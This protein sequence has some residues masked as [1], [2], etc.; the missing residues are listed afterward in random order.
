MKALVAVVTL[1][2]LLSFAGFPPAWRQVESGT[3]ENL[4]GVA[5]LNETT[6]VAVGV[7][8][9]NHPYFS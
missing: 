8:G 9:I 7:Q 6:A 5:V 4:K 2:P 1:G 3:T